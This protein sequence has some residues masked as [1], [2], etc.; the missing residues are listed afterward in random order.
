MFRVGDRVIHNTRG[1]GFVTR[2]DDITGKTQIRFDNEKSGD[3]GYDATSLASGKIQL[4]QPEEGV[5]SM[6]DAEVHEID[7]SDLSENNRELVQTEPRAHIN[8][9]EAVGC[10]LIAIAIAIVIKEGQDRTQSYSGR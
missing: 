2:V 1:R 10:F 9:W 4:E 5:S 6:S 3:H 7:C 8:V